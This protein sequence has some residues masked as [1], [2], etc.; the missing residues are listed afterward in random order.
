[1]GTVLLCLILELSTTS[2]SFSPFYAVVDATDLKEVFILMGNYPVKVQ[3]S[4]VKNVQMNYI[5]SN[6]TGTLCCPIN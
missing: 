2:L 1:M 3:H 6:N 4:L 5:Y